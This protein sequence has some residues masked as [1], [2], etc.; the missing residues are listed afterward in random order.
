M[1]VEET[2][3]PAATPLKRVGPY[4]V[5]PLRLQRRRNVFSNA[6][7]ATASGLAPQRLLV[8]RSEVSEQ[9]ITTYR[10]STFGIALLVDDSSVF[11]ALWTSGSL[12]SAPAAAIAWAGGRYAELFLQALLPV[13]FL[14]FVILHT[15]CVSED[16]ACLPIDRLAGKCATKTSLQIELDVQRP[17][18]V[19][20]NSSSTREENFQPRQ[21]RFRCQQPAADS[22]RISSTISSTTCGTGK[23]PR[24]G[25]VD[26]LPPVRC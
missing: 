8:E 24:F 21:S 26:N 22:Q 19:V 13:L 23:S 15:F 4:E 25:K 7:A 3:R 20:P 5:L 18:G 6:A 9:P 2:K 12:L 11:T 14:D 16:P 10:T 1:P 17:A